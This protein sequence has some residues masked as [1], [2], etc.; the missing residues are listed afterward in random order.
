MEVPTAMENVGRWISNRPKVLS[1][2]GLSTAF[3][4]C[5]VLLFV[6]YAGTKNIS[7]QELNDGALSYCCNVSENSTLS[8]ILA[9]SYGCKLAVQYDL[10]EAE[11]V[12]P[13]RGGE[14]CEE[15]LLNAS[16]TMFKLKRK[17]RPCIEKAIHLLS[18][19]GS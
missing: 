7:L 4:A 10:S 3:L 11:R 16:T 2:S 19:G 12:A 17:S 1:I 9:S 15:D 14:M 18:D 5:G 13:D 6:G 8:E